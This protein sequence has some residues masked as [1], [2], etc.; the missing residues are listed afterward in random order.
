VANVSILMPD[1]VVRR[2]RV[3]LRRQRGGGGSQGLFAVSA[4]CAAS[5]DPNAAR[6]YLTDGHAG[7]LITR[8][9]RAIA[10]GELVTVAGCR[11]VDYDLRLVRPRHDLPP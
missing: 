1:K 11:R 8:A 9:L 4:M 5:P 6:E 2:S 7:L 3:E 10:P